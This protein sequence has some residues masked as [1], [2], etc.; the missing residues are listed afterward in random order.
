[1]SASDPYGFDM[2]LIV[3]PGRLIL[4]FDEWVEEFEDAEAARRT[5]TAALEG[6]ARLKIDALSGRRWRWTLE[7]LD[8]AGQWAPESTIGHVNWRFWGHASVTYLRNSF[9]PR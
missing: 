3:E 4:A 6:T 9:T 1:M 8:K 5:F 2:A 7:C